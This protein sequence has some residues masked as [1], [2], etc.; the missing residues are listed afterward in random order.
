MRLKSDRVRL[1][2]DRV[3][4]RSDRVRLYR[5]QKGYRTA[6]RCDCT[7]LSETRL[8][9][10]VQQTV[11]VCVSLPSTADKKTLADRSPKNEGPLVFYIYCNQGNGEQTGNCAQPICQPRFTCNGTM[12]DRAALIEKEGKRCEI[13]HRPLIG[14][15]TNKQTA[16]ELMKVKD[17]AW[18]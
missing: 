11:G 13:Y 8:R 18:P 2:S 4:L 12:G 1:R 6:L 7:S 15:Q 5:V 3:R 17:N 16:G 9:F 10:S 14:K